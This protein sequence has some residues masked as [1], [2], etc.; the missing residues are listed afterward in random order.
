MA[1]SAGIIPSLG[2]NPITQELIDWAD[3]VIVMEP[4]HSQYVHTHFKCDPSKVHN[5]DINNKYVKNDPEL[6]REL[7]TKVQPILDLEDRL[8]EI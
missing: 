3:L 8:L 6:I 5:L 1:K 7:S 4:I 2:C